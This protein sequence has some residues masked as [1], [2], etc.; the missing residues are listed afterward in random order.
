[1][2][3]RQKEPFVGKWCL[4]GGKVEVGEHPSAAVIREFYEETGI[5]TSIERFCG[6]VS[7]LVE[8]DGAQSH[9]L[10]YVFRLRV[11]GDNMSD[12][13]TDEG[14]VQW[15]LPEELNGISIPTDLWIIEHLLLAERGPHLVELTSTAVE[16]HISAVYE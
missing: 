11:E 3:Q 7:E 8:E 5:R 16:S 9:F 10:M 2:I 15:W 13:A 6:A 4:P 1:M 14:P 12:Q